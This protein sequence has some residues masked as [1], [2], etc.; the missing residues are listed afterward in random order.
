LKKFI[1]ATVLLLNIS[2]FAENIHMMDINSDAEGDETAKIA[3]QVNTKKSIESI[4]YQNYPNNPYQNFPLEKLNKDSE[5]IVKKGPAKIV[6]IATETITATSIK[7]F[8]HFIYEYKVFGSDKR[9]KELK[10]YYVAPT[11][12]WETMDTETKKVVTKAF[13]YVNV[14]K[15]KQVGINRIETW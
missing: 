14:I 8:I 15:G 10:M 13:F 9:V 11:N 2:A 3:L 5:A 1:L 7:F 6:Q 12:L 4:L